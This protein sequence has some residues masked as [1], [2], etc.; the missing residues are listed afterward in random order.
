LSERLRR[1]IASLARASLPG[2]FFSFIA[3]Q[4]QNT[5]ALVL[6]QVE[7]QKNTKKFFLASQVPAGNCSF[8]PGREEKSVRSPRFDTLPEYH[9][10]YAEQRRL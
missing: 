2:T 8:C 5:P 9:T 10:C 7:K 3:E 4:L 1:L 6:E